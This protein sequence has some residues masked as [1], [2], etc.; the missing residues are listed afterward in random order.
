MSDRFSIRE[1]AREFG[2]HHT[3]DV[4]NQDAVLLRLREHLAKD[5]MR[6]QVF[7]V[8]NLGLVEM[9]RKNVSAGLLESFSE[10]C[11]RCN[12][13][14]VLLHEE[15]ATTGVPVGLELEDADEMV[16]YFA[17]H[18]RAEALGALG[19]CDEAI[20]AFEAADGGADDPYTSS[21]YVVL[22]KAPASDDLRSTLSG[23][24][25]DMD[26]FRFSGREIYWLL[27][28]KIS[29][30]RLFGRVFEKAIAAGEPDGF[31]KLLFGKQH[32]ELLGAHMVGAEV[33]EMIQGFGIARTL[34][35]TEAELMHTVFPHPTLSEMMHE[36]T[37][38]AFGRAIHF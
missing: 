13:R 35:T 20:A 4:Q 36:S 27:Q 28:G 2:A 5:K 31:A 9:T 32:G 23:L 37:L 26:A 30:S 16:R 22:L 18:E 11:P 29:E 7:D 3:I 21:L 34:E 24:R 17:L 19:R 1:L 15:A 10:L 8:S 25:S 33:T 14:G 12:G 38:D 6:T